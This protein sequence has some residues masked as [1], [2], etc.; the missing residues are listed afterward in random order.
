M[1]SLALTCLLWR[2]NES[3]LIDVIAQIVLLSPIPIC[4][5]GSAWKAVASLC[6]CYGRLMIE[7]SRMPLEW[8]ETMA[9]EAYATP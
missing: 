8:R 1:I 5:S 3:P 6:T 4:Q 2:Q 7:D 9:R